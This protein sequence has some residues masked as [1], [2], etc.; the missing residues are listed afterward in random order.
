MN[1]KIILNVLVVFVV[2]AGNTVS[3]ST[4]LRN[5][6]LLA[7]G[8]AREQEIALETIV[9]KED[10]LNACLLL[11]QDYFK[12]VDCNSTN[13]VL[14]GIVDQIMQRV[15]GVRSPREIVGIINEYVYDELHFTAGHRP[16]IDLQLPNKVLENKKGHCGGL[17]L[18]YLAISER[19][20]LP[21]F[22]MIVRDHIFLQYDDTINTFNIETTTKGKSFPDDYYRRFLILPQEKPARAYLRK[23]TKAEFLGI[24]LANL[25]TCLKRSGRT[26]DAIDAEKR[27]LRLFPEYPAI[28]CNIGVTY[29]NMGETR[30]AE[31]FYKEAT[32]LDPSMFEAYKS[33][34]LLYRGNGNLREA[35]NNYRKAI[36]LIRKAIKIRG[37]HITIT[38]FPDA[39][40]ERK[41]AL[42]A[43]AKENLQEE[44]ASFEQLY[45]LGTVVLEEEEYEL[46]YK[47][48]R[49]ALELRPDDPFANAF[50][51]VACFHCGR[52][53]E[54]TK[55]G[56][57]ADA[58]FGC[59]SG[60]PLSPTSRIDD[61]VECYE[62]LAVLCMQLKEY[63]LSIQS[64][65]M[66]IK[67]AGPKP[68]ICNT[69]GCGYL[70][71]GNVTRAIECFERAIQL[72]PSY[73]TARKNLE[74]IQSKKRD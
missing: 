1:R 5:W 40:E 65:N 13:M 49:R 20:E 45:G 58:E 7:R 47:L 25:G 63:D 30:K 3:G 37:V 52:Y 22:P 43:Q 21:I 56:K 23:I 4:F 26:A 66:V 73:E 50:Y 29:K 54:A 67:I 12:D 14:D 17:C 72:D 15:K 35:V 60:A 59:P 46:S 41:E 62:I 27:A 6:V 74:K 32:K 2:C 55:Y 31:Q 10:I 68:D 71:I 70:G 24:F 11:A 9:E 57:R 16:N 34:G 44:D 42:R 33:L 53:D 51:A 64:C 19:L 18:I 48:L 69:L 39:E 38:G 8:K 61:I 36:D 28:H